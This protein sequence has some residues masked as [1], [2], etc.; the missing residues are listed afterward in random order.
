MSKFK[1]NSK[2]KVIKA[3]GNAFHKAI[4]ATLKAIKNVLAVLLKLLF[5]SLDIIMHVYLCGIY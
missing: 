3:N 2:L 5:L 1:A 4:L